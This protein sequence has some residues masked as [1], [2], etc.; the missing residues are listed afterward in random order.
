LVSPSPIPVFAR[1]FREARERADLTQEEVAAQAGIDEFSASAR[2]SQY[3]TGKHVP[4]YEIARNLARALRVPVEYFYA[5]DDRTAELLLLWSQ[6]AS[7]QRIEL[8]ADLK[9]KLPS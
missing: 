4:R 3:E 6:L 9:R 5:A 1:R 2:I 8:L 7:A